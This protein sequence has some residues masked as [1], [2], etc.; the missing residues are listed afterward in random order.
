[1]WQWLSPLLNIHLIL[2]C[3][4]ASLVLTTVHTTLA[5]SSAHAVATSTG[6]TS[7]TDAALHWQ[8]GKEALEAAEVSSKQIPTEGAAKT[9]FQDAINH[10]QRYVDRY[11]GSPNYLEAH[12][13]LGLAYQGLN[14][15]AKAIAPLKYCVNTSALEAVLGLKCRVAL[16]RAYLKQKKHHEAELIGLEAEPIAEGAK[17][18]PLALN[19]TLE[20]QLIKAEALLLLK[21]EARAAGI[22]QRTLTQVAPDAAAELKGQASLLQLKLKLTECSHLPSQN[23]LDEG[24]VQSELERKGTCLLEAL[25]VMNQTLSNDDLASARAATTVAQ[26]A[27]ESYLN[28]CQSPPQKLIRTSPGLS[29][30][31]KRRA[32]LELT[33]HLIQN[34]RKKSEAGIELIEGWKA[35]TPS[36]MKALLSQM[37]RSLQASPNS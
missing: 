5:V 33:D 26:N 1:M 34:C 12:Y 2:K 28:L 17:K 7:K 21:Q 6:P 13:Y 24:Q 29:R 14:Q 19:L 31:E 8:L 25:V 9:Q 20:L 15:T 11:A 18:T 23:S 32:Y 22:L 3:M 16:G 37:A 35:E 30:K 10:L 27:F 4:T 36:R